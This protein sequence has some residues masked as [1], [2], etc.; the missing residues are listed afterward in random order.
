MGESLDIDAADA[1]TLFKLLDADNSNYVTYDEFVEGC[2]ALRGVAKTV[3][4]KE[5]MYEL[6][7][8]R[9]QLGGTAGQVDSLIKCLFQSRDEAETIIEL[10]KLTEISADLHQN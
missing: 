4:L 10:P 5:L 6:R 1:W 8:I 7:W 9:R 2:L 3:G